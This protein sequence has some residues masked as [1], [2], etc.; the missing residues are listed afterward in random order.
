MATKNGN[1]EGITD[2]TQREIPDFTADRLVFEN[3]K[4]E[5]VNN[6]N[7]REIKFL[8]TF[9]IIKLFFKIIILH[10]PFKI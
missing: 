1:K 2:V 9:K 7:K 3:I 5:I 10:N 4:I 6:K 8:F